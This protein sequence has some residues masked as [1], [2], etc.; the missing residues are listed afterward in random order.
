MPILRVHNIIYARALI[1]PAAALRYRFGARIRRK[2][3]YISTT[4]PSNL[5]ITYA[6]YYTRLLR[7]DDVIRVTYINIYI[8]IHSLPTEHY[9][10][11]SGCYR[12]VVTA[13]G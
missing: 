3:F 1:C 10:I 8:F 2:S 5:H 6:V 13:S 9:F 12:V 4:D 7:Y 11:A